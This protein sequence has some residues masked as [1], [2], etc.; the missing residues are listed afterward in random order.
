MLSSDLD[1]EGLKFCFEERVTL[2]AKR[3][4]IYHVIAPLK[5]LYCCALT[6]VHSSRVL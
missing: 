2:G 5:V 4:D 1:T 6:E 3:N